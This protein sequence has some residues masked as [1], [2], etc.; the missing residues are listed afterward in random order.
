MVDGHGCEASIIARRVV[1][2][3]GWL[4]GQWSPIADPKLR[5]APCRLAD[6]QELEMEPELE[7]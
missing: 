6:L 3:R 2:G 5:R 4:V 7:R 1:S